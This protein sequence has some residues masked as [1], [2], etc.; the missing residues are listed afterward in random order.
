MLQQLFGVDSSELSE[1]GTLTPVLAGADGKALDL[2]LNTV[3]LADGTTRTDL[4]Y[5]DGDSWKNLQTNTKVTQDVLNRLSHDQLG[6]SRTAHTLGAV[7]K[8]ETGKAEVTVTIDGVNDFEELQQA[9]ADLNYNGAIRF[10]IGSGFAA[11][12]DGS[13]GIIFSSTLAI[14]K[15]LTI[16]GWVDLNGDTKV[17]SNERI[18]FSGNNA[19]QIMNISGGSAV[20]IDNISFRNGK[21]ASANG[22]AISNAGNLFIDNAEFVNNN[23]SSKGNA[24]YNSGTLRVSESTFSG[25][26]TTVTSGGDFYNADGTAEFYHTLFKGAAKN[27]GTGA[28]LYIG[29]GTVSV[30]DSTISGYRGKDANGHVVYIPIRQSRPTEIGSTLLRTWPAV[31]VVLTF[32]VSI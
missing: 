24:I 20:S 29:K 31:A 3:E 10:D 8:A 9:V 27:S 17:D 13:Y 25:N 28:A 2:R 7:A 26:D 14:S 19:V 1:N 23:G 4:Q 16:D 11:N 32:G 22:G 6:N 18:V 5:F 12:M 30:I 15:T 21:A